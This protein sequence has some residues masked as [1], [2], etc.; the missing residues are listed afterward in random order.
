MN[1]VGVLEMPPVDD[2]TWQ[3]TV[4]LPRDLEPAIKEVARQRLVP[5]TIALRQLIKERL[6][7]LAADARRQERTE[8]QQ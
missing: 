7:Q 3:V 6:D 2:T 4:R 5:P 8:G 1:V